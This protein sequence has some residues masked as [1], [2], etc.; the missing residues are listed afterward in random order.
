MVLKVFDPIFNKDGRTYI[1][2]TIKGN[3]N[4]PKFG[5]DVKRMFNKDAPVQAATAQAA[6][7][8]RQE[9]RNQAEDRLTVSLRAVRA[10]VRAASAA[11]VDKS[12][13]AAA[14]S[15]QNFGEWSM[16]RRCISS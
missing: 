15:A 5:V 13:Q 7:T 6:R 9:S 8:P 11:P 1:P 2:I 14:T 12:G 16:R 3:R 4:D 10:R